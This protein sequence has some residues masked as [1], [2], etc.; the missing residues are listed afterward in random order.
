MTEYNRLIKLTPLE[1]YFFGGERVF[2]F[3]EENRHYFIRSMDAPSQT[4]LFGALRFIGKQKTNYNLDEAEKQRIGSESYCLTERSQNFGEIKRISPL[5]ILDEKERFLAR[6]PFDHKIMRETESSNTASREFNTRYTHFSDYST[7]MFTTHGKRCF[8]T[9][10]VAKDGVADNW[11]SLPDGDIVNDLFANTEHVGINRRLNE[12]GFF[13]REYKIFSNKYRGSSF[14]FFAEVGP[15]YQAE[16]HEV[17]LGQNKSPFYSEIIDWNKSDSQ[18]PDLS[19]LIREGMAYAQS[20]IYYPNIEELYK[21]CDF[22]CVQTKSF[23][24]FT[25]VYNKSS[26]F[27]G[28]ARSRFKKGEIIMLVKA[29][30]VF[31]PRNPT[32]FKKSIESNLHAVKAGFNQI[33]IGGSKQ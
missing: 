33:I 5:Y 16:N 23:R 22:V 24:V 25:T 19:P 7:Q 14:A 6:T 32:D 28:Y 9:D 8:P 15:D 29:G 31:M 17:F 27:D 2:E 30:S 10:Y 20:D 3:G 13:K 1:P 12:N 11:I 26:A 4:T 18:I 21:T